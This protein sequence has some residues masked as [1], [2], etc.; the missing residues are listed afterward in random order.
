MPYL[1]VSR[2]GYMFFILSQRTVASSSVSM[3]SSLIAPVIARFSPTLRSSNF[4]QR[5]PGVSSRS[6]PIEV[7]TH[8]LFSVT[9]GLSSTFAFLSAARRFI[10]ELLPTFGMPTI[11]ARRCLPSMPLS[12]QLFSFSSQSL[13]AAGAISGM[14]SFVLQS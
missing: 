1:S 3:I 10:S 5:T 12:C 4:G 13:R 8:C 2:R 7:V 6:M 11:I 9:P 14:P